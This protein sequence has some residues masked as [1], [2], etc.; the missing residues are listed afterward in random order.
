MWS[1]NSIKSFFGFEN[2]EVENGGQNEDKTVPTNTEERKGLFSQLSGFIGKDVTSMISLPVWIFEPLSFLQIMCE[3]MQYAYLLEKANQSQDSA[4]RMAYLVAFIAGG[5][6]LATRT[7]KP[8]NPILGETFE[9]LNDKWKFMAEQVSHHPPIGVSEA[10]SDDFF[11][12]LEMALKTKFK[13]N[14]SEVYVDGD[15][16]MEL[17][18]T[19]DKFTWNHLDTCAHNVILG[20]MWVDHFGTLEVTNTTTNETARIVF[21]RCGWLGAGRFELNGDILD[22]N[23]VVK[24]KVT[25][26]WNE[27][28]SYIKIT[29]G[30]PEAPIQIWK[31][32]AAPSNKWNHNDFTTSLNTMSAEYQTML[33]PNDSR[34]RG[35]RLALEKGD[36]DLAGKEKQRLEEKQR[37]ERKE[38]E[39]KKI[40]YQPKYFK[41]EEANGKKKWLRA[42]DY[43]AEREERI[44]TKADVKDVVVEK[45]E[46][47]VDAN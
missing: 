14:S 3:P 44:K 10:S 12:H 39:T 41:C 38:R 30:Q 15:S 28:I 23:G 4:E 19:G 36:T 18:K 35:D 45:K 27:T 20:S 43:W 47:P 22:S 34:L 29:N 7:K 21:T 26:K 42:A 6:S 1:W 31:K 16:W 2:L 40:E 33:P 8:F 9:Y 32:E 17:K 11:V 37:A 24:G 25:G 46:N 5:Y 13:G